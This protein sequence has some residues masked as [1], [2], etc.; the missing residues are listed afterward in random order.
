[1]TMLKIPTVFDQHPINKT[2]HRESS[3]S[4]QMVIS[5]KKAILQADSRNVTQT[6][7]RDVAISE[8]STP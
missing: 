4:S 5:S 1:M 6:I 3:E 7:P 2:V 8:D